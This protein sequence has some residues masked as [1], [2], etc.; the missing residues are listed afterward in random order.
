MVNLV[1][2][3]E[4]AKARQARQRLGE[5]IRHRRAQT[6]GQPMLLHGDD[7]SG[8]A[9]CLDNRLGINRLDRVHAEHTRF[10]SIGRKPFRHVH[11][12]L[13]HAAGADERDVTTVA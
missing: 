2:H 13:K 7:R 5:H 6:A 3:A 1:R 10:N 11:G 12:F 9:R 4:L 8:L